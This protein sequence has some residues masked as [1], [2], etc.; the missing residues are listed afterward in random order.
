MPRPTRRFFTKARLALLVLAALVVCSAAVFHVVERR[1]P[2]SRAQEHYER[3]IILAEHE[4]DEKAAIEFRNALK[5][6]QTMLPAWRKLAQ[7][8]EAAQHWT[9]VIESLQSIVSLD[10]GDIEARLKLAKL[11]TVNGRI[12]QALE[13]TKPQEGGSDN[14]SRIQAARAVILYKLNDKLEAVR[15]ARAALLADHSNAD[16]LL[17]LAKNRMVAGDDEGALKILEAGKNSDFGIELT[18]LEIYEKLHNSQKIEASLL[19][20]IN[21]RPEEAAFR[22]KLIQFYIDSHRDADAQNEIH[23]ALSERGI[24]A[25]AKLDVIR[26]LYSVKGPAAARQELVDLINAGGEVFSYQTALADLEYTLGNFADAERRMQNLA[27]HAGSADE[28]T[29]ARNILAEIFLKRNKIDDAEKLVSET[30]QRDDKNANGLKLR[31]AIRL[32]RGQIESA[33]ADLQ[34]SLGGS[35]NSAETILLLAQA[36][37][38]EGSIGRAEKTYADAVRA[39]NFDPIVGFNY[40]S[41]LIRRGSGDRA[42]QFL[43]ALSERLPKNMKILSAL[44][45]VDLIRGDWA[46]AE[47]VAESMR[48]AGGNH[49]ITDQILG[50]ALLGQ[51]KYDEGITLFQSAVDSSP[52]A[53]GPVSSLATALVRAQKADKAEAVVK[54]ALQASPENEQLQLLMGSVQLASGARDRALQSFKSA[55]EKHPKSANGYLELAKLY[56]GERQFDEAISTVRSGLEVQPD[57]LDLRLALADALDKL[58]RFDLAIAEYEKI[59]TKSPNSLIAANNLASLLSDHRDDQASL[60]RAQA[61]AAKLHGLPVP[62]FR[63]TLGWVTYR[64]GNYVGAVSLLEKAAAK[65]P[66]ALVRYHLGMAYIAVRDEAKASEQLRAALRLE[67]DSGLEEKINRALRQLLG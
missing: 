34:R 35:P 32:A 27:D 52:F 51:H 44:A 28:K 42:E 20:L 41:F 5:L 61:L 47:A 24:G 8:E 50:A 63:D 4:D 46:G 64:Q 17:V 48:K 33:I 19:L 14:N 45:N 26:Y 55:I 2:E 37:E 60:E 13:L 57:N 11:L 21:Q 22:K 18:R 15:Q 25:D 67:P 16:A 54:L 65:L 23:K 38:Q 36:Y 53:V 7:I 49:E 40:A 56:N 66:T 9:G 30:L 31:G 3:G 29:I 1:S 39:S 62:Q 59:L 10:P 12:Y 43:T 58:A 6:N